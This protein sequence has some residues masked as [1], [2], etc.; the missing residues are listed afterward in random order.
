MNDAVADPNGPA[1]SHDGK[2]M[3]LADSARG[4]VHPPGSRRASASAART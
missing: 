2:H 3:Y 1:F 4:I